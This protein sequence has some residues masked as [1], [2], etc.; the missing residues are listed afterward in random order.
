[1]ENNELQ[2]LWKAVDSE[3][4]EKPTDELNL[5]LL[6]GT[7]ETINKFTVIIG[8]DIAVCAGLIIFLTATA[9]NRQSDIIYLINN[10]ILGLMT[11]LSFLGSIYTMNKLKNNKYN[12]SLKD[13]LEQRIELLTKWLKGKY[14][15]LY[16]IIIPVLMVLI[17]LSIHVYYEYKPFNEVMQNEESLYS[18][19]AGFIVGLFVSYYAVSKIRRYQLKNLEFLKELYD[20]LC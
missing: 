10:L 14:S 7:R 8:V 12:L 4:K 3:I 2:D 15:K 20:R 5:L 6:A 17:I 13:W 16:I 1:M 18:L 11:F 19:T 9:I